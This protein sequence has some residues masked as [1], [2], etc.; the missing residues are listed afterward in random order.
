MATRD[1]SKPAARGEQAPSMKIIRRVGVELN[2]QTK[3]GKRLI[4]RQRASWNQGR[5]ELRLVSQT[6][7]RPLG[8]RPEERE[9]DN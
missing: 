2:H 7:G 8:R 9:H 5:P 1:G 3:N 6:P 4:D